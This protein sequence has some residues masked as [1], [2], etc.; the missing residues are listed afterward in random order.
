MA[1]NQ[2][3]LAARAT[4][5]QIGCSL[6]SLYLLMLKILREKAKKSS[7]LISCS[8]AKSRIVPIVKLHVIAVLSLYLQPSQDLVSSKNNFNYCDVQ[9]NLLVRIE[10]DRT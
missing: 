3:I 10:K 7:G 4:F 1:Q 5:S 2:Y 8:L 6:H 9:S